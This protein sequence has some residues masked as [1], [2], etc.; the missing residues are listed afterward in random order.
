MRAKLVLCLLALPIASCFSPKYHDGNLQC[1][2]SGQCP[3]GYHCAVDQTCWRNG[4]DPDASTAR[5]DASRP[6]AK[7]LPEAG[8]E[9]RDAALPSSDT[10]ALPDVPGTFDAP[11]AE[12]PAVPDAFPTPDAP[13]TRDAAPAE[14]IPDAGDGEAAG[15]GI[16]IDQVAV[17][18]ARVTCAKNF[19]CC[20]QADL[21]GKTLGN[22]EQNLANLFQAA[23]KA[24]TEGVSRGRTIYYPERAKQCVEEL[25]TTSCQD[26]PLIPVLELPAICANAI[27]PQIETGGPCRSVAEC[28][29]GLCS[30]A[31]SNK[32]GTCLPKAANGQSCVQV[33]GQNSCWAGFYCDSTNTCSPTKSEGTPCAGN[34]E[35]TSMTCGAA[36]DAGTV[37]LPALCYS[38]G[39]LLPP[40]C[41]FGGRP[42]AFAA[43]LVLTT[44]ALVWRRRRGRGRGRPAR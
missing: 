25:S 2:A 12:A 8:A 24:V 22:C 18:Y 34:P 11:G 5:V 19:A 30:G 27:E 37:C 20:A 9:A 38:N 3:E 29:S 15:P 31:T 43:G 17:E 32:D 14:A 44:L 26:W 6:D 39:P 13:L 10:L 7:A 41:S 4:S 42:S 33:F 23:V 35:C 21:K 36:P 28:I 1:T 16:A 40:A